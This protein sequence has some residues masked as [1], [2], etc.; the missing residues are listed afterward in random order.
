[1]ISVYESAYQSSWYKDSFWDK[2]FLFMD[3]HD[4]VANQLSSKNTMENS[5]GYSFLSSSY[6]S[7][8]DTT[9]AKFKSLFKSSWALLV[10]PVTLPFFLVTWLPL[11]GW[12]YLRMLLLSNKSLKYAGGYHNFSADKCDIRQSI[13]RRCGKFREAVSCIRIGLKKKD[14]SLHT[15]ALFYIGLAENYTRDLNEW[16]FSKKYIRKAA[17]LAGGVEKY[18]VNQAIRIYKNCG[19]LMN[20]IREDGSLF[21]KKAKELAESNGV[22]DQLLKIGV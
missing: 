11:G 14:I 8:A 1:M 9:A 2:S 17:L 20:K 15:C 10:L 6:Y 4:C 16:N 3:S 5:D 13:L 18:D 12:C 19:K 7:I 21:L 22:K